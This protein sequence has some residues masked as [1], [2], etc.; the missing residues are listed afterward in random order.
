[1][2]RSLCIIPVA[3]GLGGPSWAKRGCAAGAQS[4][5]DAGLLD[6]LNAL[7]CIYRLLPPLSS[8]NLPHADALAPLCRQLADVVERVIEAGELPLVLGG[9]H[10]I[11]AGTWRGASRKQAAPFGLL[12]LDAH[13]DAH[14]PTDS[15]SGNRHGMP[16]ASL[17]GDDVPDFAGIPGPGPD[18]RHISLVG[19]RSFEAPEV[20]RLYQH[21]VRIFG[22]SEIRHKGL[23]RVMK[24]ALER[25]QTG[26]SGWG[27]SLDL[28]A[29]DPS[30]APGVSTPAAT[31][32][33][34]G[35]MI[36]ELLGI[37]YDRHL[38]AIEIVEYNPLQDRE[39]KTA[40]LARILLQALFQPTTSL[41]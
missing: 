9:D 5:L 13:L 19:S 34:S 3:C 8:A 40:H 32:L 28:D 2:K 12:W 14:T 10:A 25:V 41:P 33:S 26:T 16:L 36:N 37:G 15:I 31:G 20:E 29:L 1:M 24:A 27:V 4:L 35:E 38:S 23:S 39:G 21:H 11:A 6:G 7:G 22:M 17:L 18:A 30:E